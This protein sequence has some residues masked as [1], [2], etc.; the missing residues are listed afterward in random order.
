[1][2]AASIRSLMDR[3]SIIGVTPGDP[4]GIGA[5]TIVKAIPKTSSSANV[6][7]VGDVEQLTEAIAVCE[8]DLSINRITS[9]SEARFESDAI[10][11]LDTGNVRSVKYGEIS[12]VYGDATFADLETAQRLVDDGTIDAI[13]MGPI[14]SESNE[15]SDRDYVEPLDMLADTT[16]S[17]LV[18]VLLVQ[19]GLRV[20]HLSMHVPFRNVIDYV[21]EDRLHE[22]IRLTEEAVRSIGIDSPDVAVAGLNP[23]AGKEPKAADGTEEAEV[24]PAVE[25]ARAD[26]RSVAGPEPPDTVFARA[27]TGEFDAVV[28]L[29]H[30]QGHIPVKLLGFGSDDNIGA[31]LFLGLPFVITSVSHGPAHDIAGQGVADS[32]GMEMAIGLAARAARS[33]SP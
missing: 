21:E 2:A 18:S 7:V 28:A 5:E 8:S 29:Y 16:G 15:L 30:D 9:A 24:R 12:G 26:G 25:R 32:K 23:H 3:G 4:A 27:Y 11:V 10:D 31:N 22:V 1:M 17:D 14:N 20:S 6:V 33:D 19:N 13:V